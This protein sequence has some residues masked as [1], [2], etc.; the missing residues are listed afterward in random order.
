MRCSSTLSRASCNEL[1]Y[2]YVLA[3]VF[4]VIAVHELIGQELPGATIISVAHR[5]AL[6]AFHA[7]RLELDR[8]SRDRHRERAR[9]QEMVNGAD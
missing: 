8:A 2:F 1:G 9:A 6:A 3:A 4:I 7:R 5:P